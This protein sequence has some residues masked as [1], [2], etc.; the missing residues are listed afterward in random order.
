MI[1]RSNI[2][3]RE[4][5][6]TLRDPLYGR[7]TPGKPITIQKRLISHIIPI[8]KAFVVI[9]L[10]VM[11]GS[12]YSPLGC[13]VQ[14]LMSDKFWY[15]KQIIIFFIIYFIINLG[16]ET[17]SK[18]TDP[19]QQLIISICTLILYNIIARLGDIWWDKNPWYWP[20][21]MSWFAIL[22]F[23]LLSIYI[24]DD[25][26]KYYIAENASFVYGNSIDSIKSI[27][28]GMILF[29]LI[30]IGWGFIKAVL[31]AREKYKAAF[32]FFKFLFGAPLVEEQA[33]SDNDFKRYKKSLDIKDKKTNILGSAMIIG[34]LLIFTFSIGYIA[35]Y[36]NKIE[37]FLRLFKNEIK[38]QGIKNKLQ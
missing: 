35:V 9:T 24:L 19:I 21:P 33:C 8:L 20:G 27:E 17:I 25:L 36:K 6:T 5:K 1:D 4:E 34:V 31:N 16:G 2:L 37:K 11:N 10:F 18:L 12:G 30:L 22:V 14:Y 13:K 29:T 23:P 28:I 38:N 15:N 3:V 32:S 26:R 7:E